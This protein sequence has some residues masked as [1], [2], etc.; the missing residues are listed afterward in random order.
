MRRT[1]RGRGIDVTSATSVAGPAQDLAGT[2][3]GLARTA[4]GPLVL[5]FYDGYERKA[6]PG[7]GGAIYS[8]ARRFARY[9]W[10]NLRRKQVRTGFYVCFLSL[11]RSLEMIGCDVRVNDFA[12]AARRPDYPIG[13]AGYATVVDKVRQLPNPRIFAPGDYGQPEASRAVAADP[14]FKILTQLCDWFVALYRPFCGDKMLALNVGVD[15]EAWPDM[16]AHPK[17]NDVLIYDKIRWDR[18]ERVPQL[19]DA[20]VRHLEAQGRS[21]EILRYGYHHQSEF[22]A[23]V[24]RSRSLLFLCEHETQ[25]LAYQEAMSSNVPVLAWDEG[26]MVDPALKQYA[27]AEMGVSSVPYFDARCGVKFKVGGLEAAFDTFW[28]KLDQFRPREY[29]LERLSMEGAARAY[30]A[31]YAGIATPPGVS[32]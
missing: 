24:E 11:K 22:R 15:S 27:T 21:Y 3:P 20:A 31:A 12:L 30:L 6:A 13:L 32:P 19:L 29:V 7:V 4:K 18:D 9:A 1:A 23:S 5:L 25:G 14:R 26:V 17:T 8:Q 16:A 28:A 10:R 2:P